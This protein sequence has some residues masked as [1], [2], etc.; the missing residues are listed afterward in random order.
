M[1]GMT[2]SSRHRRSSRWVYR[3]RPSTTG[4][5]TAAPWQRLAPGIILMTTGH[6]TTGQLVTAAL[7]ARG[8]GRP[9][10]RPGGMSMTWCPTR[11]S[12]TAAACTSLFPTKGRSGSDG[13]H[14]G[15]AQS[16]HAALAVAEVCPLAPV[17]RAVIDAARRLRDAR[18]DHRADRRSSAA[19]AMHVRRSSESS[20]PNAARAARRRGASF[21]RS[22]PG[23]APPQRPTPGGCGG[24][25]PTRAVVERARSRSAGRFLGTA[26]AWF[27]EVALAW[28][29]NSLA[30]HLNPTDYEREQERTARFVAAGRARVCRRSRPGCAPMPARFSTSCARHTGTPLPD[31]GPRY[32][33]PVRA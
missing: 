29:I 3:S 12:S 9:P 26:D 17:P 24:V 1:L 32:V 14:P 33:R 8:P 6:P 21:A 11:A 4:A 20:S 5:G 22:V 16:P 15:R 23:S 28:E 19:R 31:R 27:D 2:A 7:V 30:W 25:G 18:R 10:H 13:A